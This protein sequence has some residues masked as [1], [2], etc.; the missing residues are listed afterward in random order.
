ME[1]TAAARLRARAVRRASRL[2]AAGRIATARA[3]SAAGA[4]Y[5]V[6]PPLQWAGEPFQQERPLVIVGGYASSPGFYRLLARSYEAAG[7][8]TVHVLP[9]IDNAYADLRENIRRLRHYVEGLECEID[10]VGHSEGGLIARGYCKFDGGTERVRHLVTL[11]TPN[12]GI[13]FDRLDPARFVPHDTVRRA[14]ELARAAIA[15][16]VEELSSV[17]LGQMRVGS[18][19]MRELNADPATPGPTQY[20][21]VA[22]RHDG[23]IPFESAALRDAPN[24]ANVTLEDGWLLGN[25]AAIATTSHRAFEV[26][27]DFLRR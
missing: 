5:D 14:S 16:L 20:L 19:F 21:A 22:S 17:A 1:T 11:G 24:V 6:L 25:H 27:L 23:V 7:A 2:A 12:D 8:T 4:L 15:P 9:L 13:S 10:I 18:P 3:V 26:T